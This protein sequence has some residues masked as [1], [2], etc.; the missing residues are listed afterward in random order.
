MQQ[1]SWSAANEISNYV[2]TMQYSIGMFADNE[3]EL[4][5]KAKTSSSIESPA[6]ALLNRKVSIRY[7]DAINFLIWDQQGK[8]VIDSE[9]TQ[10]N[11]PEVYILPSISHTNV[12]YAVR[13]HRNSEHDHFNII[14]PWNHENKFLGVFGVSFP[15]ELVQPLLFKHQNVDYQLVLW[16]EDSPGFVELASPDSDLQLVNDVYLEPEDMSRVGAVASIGGTQWDIVSLHSQNLFKDKLKKIVFNSMLKFLAILV[17]V[18]VTAKLYQ[19]E[20]K[21]RY[22]ANEKIRKTQE[23]LQLALESR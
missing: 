21:R 15:A 23:R 5:E 13:M 14:V 7:P 17:A 11:K 9:G 8:L 12:E 19:R 2:E 3:T 20:T 1:S 6:I 22:E 16:R 4:L 10:I 18:V